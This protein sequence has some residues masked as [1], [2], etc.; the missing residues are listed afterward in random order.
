MWIESSDGVTPIRTRKELPSRVWVEESETTG[1]YEEV[2]VGNAATFGIYQLDTS[3]VR[4]DRDHVRLIVN[5]APGVFRVA[6][7]FDQATADRNAAEAA[8]EAERQAARNKVADLQAFIDDQN[9]TNAEVVAELKAHARILQRLIRDT[10][11]A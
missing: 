11:G 2:T 4:P 10:F 9:V 5:D 8:D 6:W 1:R 7:V 3:A